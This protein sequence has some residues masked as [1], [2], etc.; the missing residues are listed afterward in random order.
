MEHAKS[1][2]ETES[3]SERDFSEEIAY[4]HVAKFKETTKMRKGL[5]ISKNVNL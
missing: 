4:I 5:K 3:I 2:K 1:Q